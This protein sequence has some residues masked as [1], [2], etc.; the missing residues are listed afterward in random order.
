MPTCCRS[1]RCAAPQLRR[2]AGQ[3]AGITREAYARAAANL[4]P[5]PR[6]NDHTVP[7][8]ARAKF[9]QVK[10][11]LYPKASGQGITANNGH[12]AKHGLEIMKY[13]AHLLGAHLEITPRMD[14]GTSVRCQLISHL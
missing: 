4:F 12:R 1:K 8:A 11:T 7:E 5:V 13:R 14:G 10:V 9:G 6:Y 3:I 2:S